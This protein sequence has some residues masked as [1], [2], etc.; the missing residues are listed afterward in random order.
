MS[1]QTKTADVTSSQAPMWWI[2]AFQNLTRES[3][4]SGGWPQM[5]WHFK[6]PANG[7]TVDL[8]AD[9]Q[10]MVIWPDCVMPSNRFSMCVGRCSVAGA[11]EFEGKIG[12]VSGGAF[13]DHPRVTV[14]SN[15]VPPFGW[16]LYAPLRFADGSCLVS[17][18]HEEH[19]WAQEFRGVY[20]IP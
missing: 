3:S 20:G 18:Y 5:S 16:Y 12:E 19:P 7:L 1:P 8:K 6:H 14:Q 13:Y 11:I 17:N 10:R 4:R 9:V 15:R 2:L